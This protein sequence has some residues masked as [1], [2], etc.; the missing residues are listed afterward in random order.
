MNV[1]TRNCKRRRLTL[2]GHTKN[3]PDYDLIKI[4]KFSPA[5]LR[6]NIMKNKYLRNKFQKGGVFR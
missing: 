3:M 6:R 1:L 2:A 5:Q 4:P